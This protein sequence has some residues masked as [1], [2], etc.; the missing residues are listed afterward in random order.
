M[1]V[2]K[3]SMSFHFCP[4]S[5]LKKK[6]SDTAATSDLIIS[7]SGTQLGTLYYKYPQLKPLLKRLN[8][9]MERT[10]VDINY[11]A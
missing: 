6:Y 10:N 1:N 3:I 2:K 9:I 5:V 8:E 4:V 11:L 7:H